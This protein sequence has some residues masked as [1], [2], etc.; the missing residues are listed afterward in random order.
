[1]TNIVG[2][3]SY[4]HRVL[5]IG[6]F[7]GTEGDWKTMITPHSATGGSVHGALLFNEH[8]ASV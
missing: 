8:R 7:L 2:A 3:H 6:K 4:T 5:K 1:M